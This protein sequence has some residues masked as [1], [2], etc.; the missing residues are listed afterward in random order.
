M[1]SDRD[2]V[3][4]KFE[5]ME[6]DPVPKPV[7][8]FISSRAK[9]RYPVKI[10]RSTTAAVERRLSTLQIGCPVPLEFFAIWY[11]ECDREREVHKAFRNLRIQG[12]WF[13]PHKPLLDFMEAVKAEQPDW[14]TRMHTI[15]LRRKAA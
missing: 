14:Q 12:E 13:K 10:G 11:P 15:W 1:I 4:A 5:G 2:R 7:V 8:Y 9:S 6:V 3:L